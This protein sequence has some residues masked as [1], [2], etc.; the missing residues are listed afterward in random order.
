[1][2]ETGSALINL[3]T[4]TDD[5]LNNLL[6]DIQEEQDRRKW[7]RIQEL[8]GKYI[9]PLS[10]P[11]LHRIQELISTE[12][13]KRETSPLG[14]EEQNGDQKDI[15]TGQFGGPFGADWTK[16]SSSPMD[17]ETIDV[18]VSSRE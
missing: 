16:R 8:L 14:Y 1:M 10:I 5:D 11:D 3:K 18:E 12:I 2:A 15:L 9:F 17:A 7:Q 4:L 13:H 6:I